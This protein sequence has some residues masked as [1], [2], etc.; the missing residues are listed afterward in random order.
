MSRNRNEKSSSTPQRVPIMALNISPSPVGTKNAMKIT[1]VATIRSLTQADTARE[2]RES[3]SIQIAEH[4]TIGT[5]IHRW[6]HIQPFLANPDCKLNK[7]KQR[8]HVTAESSN[9]STASFPRT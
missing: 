8:T 4:N 1:P 2:R 3:V 7:S 5:T 9:P 6:D